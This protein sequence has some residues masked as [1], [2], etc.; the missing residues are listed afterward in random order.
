MK[1]SYFFLFFFIFLIGSVSAVD[2]TFQ[3]NKQFDLKRTCSNQGFFCDGD[4]DCNITISY[5]NG[6]AFINNS[7]MTND[8]SYRNITITQAQNRELGILKAI[9]SCNNGTDAGLE[10]F[11][12][13]I[14]ADGREFKDFPNQFFIILLGVGFV[15]LGSLVDKLRLFKYLGGVLFMVMG[16][17][18][19]YPGFNFIN[20]STLMGKAFGFILIG[21]G[22]YFLIEDSFS[23]SKQAEHPDQDFTE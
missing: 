12:I 21:M 1:F 3:V 17:L 7:P 2:P 18:T 23:R 14:T 6:T 10:T 4:F 5:P 11:D 9:H 20:W 8:V 15:V 19:L 16:V 13:F 22:F